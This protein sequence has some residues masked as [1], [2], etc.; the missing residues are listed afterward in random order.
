MADADEHA[1]LSDFLSDCETLVPVD[2]AAF[3]DARGSFVVLEPT[4]DQDA[5]DGGVDVH[6]FGTRTQALAAVSDL[7]EASAARAALSRAT[8][9]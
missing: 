4:G 2:V 5:P 6:W 8:G 7:W 9:V 3:N 1:D